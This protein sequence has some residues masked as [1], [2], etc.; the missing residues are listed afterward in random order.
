MRVTFAARM[1]IVAI[2][3]FSCSVTHAVFESCETVM[4]SGSRSCA[5]VGLF[6]PKIRTL[7]SSIAGE[8]APKPAVRTLD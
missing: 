3:L 7:A 5:T 6:F 1:S 2:A 4:Y 8:N